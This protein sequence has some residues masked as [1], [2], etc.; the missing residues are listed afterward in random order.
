LTGGTRCMSEK[1]RIFLICLFL[2]AATLLA[3]WQVGNSEFINYD[4]ND[5]VTENLT[6]Q[7]GLT[8]E[9]IRW[10]FT[11]YY[12]SNWHPLTWLSHMMDVHLFGLS[13]RGHHL[14]NLLL[15]L[16]N[17]LLL[18][19]VLHRMTKA[20]WQSAF[21]AA[22]FALHPLHVESVAWA[23]ERKDVLSAFFWM[24]TLGAYVFYVE[25]P[26]R[27][28]YLAV[29]LLFALG[30]MAKP[31]LVTLPFVLLL[32]D[33]WPLGRFEGDKSTE[34]L[35]M[36]P[37][38]SVPA[39]KR[40]GKSGKK[41]AMKSAM[42]AEPPAAARSPRA[43]MWLLLR[44]KIPLFAL[45]AISC[46]VTYF[47]QQAGGAV[48]SIEAFPLGDRISNAFVSYIL[49]VG[50]M[51]WP[52]GLAVLY[53]HP[54]SLPLWQV[55]GAVVVLAAATFLVFWRAKRFPYLT[56]GWLW[57]L[58]TLVPV[59]GIVQV[60]GHALADRYTYIPLIGLFIAAA[61]GIPELLKGWRWRKEALVASSALILLGLAAVTWIQ[62]GYW[63][64]S[65]TLYDHA[66]KVT[67][68]N[69]LIYNNRGAAYNDLGNLDRAISDFDRAIE[70]NPKYDKAH[71]NRGN[72]W[73]QKGDF[74]R[75]IAD[76]DRVIE[77]N[78]RYA[79]AYFNRGNAYGETGRLDRAIADFDRAIEINP[80]YAR[81]YSSRAIAY[82]HLKDG[83]KACLD[84]RKACQSGDC[85]GY[86]DAKRA[87]ICQ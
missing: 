25:R 43:A 83:N 44:E 67:D 80:N 22:L 68:R 41:Q 48:A 7:R 35:R 54:G 10:A 16:A 6:V 32:L 40:K 3:F 57:Y 52:S 11:T 33:Y 47:A 49:Y 37:V 23:A 70:I 76:F 2:A 85:R 31:M 62:V 20:L 60:G 64:N 72:A 28:R 46:V 86:Q 39:E 14:T 5:Y 63:K 9:G 55:L 12:A 15:H 29:L 87:G 30:L 69:S 27:T 59:I 61:W 1:N 24:L 84:F 66:L 45:T 34:A 79:A 50:K 51:F 26:G 18:F 8:A 42:K 19:L 75:A 81:A 71:Y 73:G 78:P 21:A 13:P 56:V 17:T 58:G 77:I 74:D 82:L 4:D 38:K 65:L 36:E 53:P